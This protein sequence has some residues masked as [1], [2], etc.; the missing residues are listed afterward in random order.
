MP[1]L[2]SCGPIR[3]TQTSKKQKLKRGSA[4]PINYVFSRFRES[5]VT[6]TREYSSYRKKK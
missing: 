6:R 1:T 3:M 5:L 4:C 2:G